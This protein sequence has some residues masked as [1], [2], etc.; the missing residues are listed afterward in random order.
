MPSGCA[1]RESPLS[2]LSPEGGRAGH[3]TRIPSL[4]GTKTH[5]SR[6]SP[7]TS[8]PA[9]F[10]RGPKV[11]L[12]STQR[13]MTWSVLRNVQNQR[14]GERTLAGRSQQPPFLCARPPPLG[15]SFLPVLAARGFLAAHRGGRP[16]PRR[17]APPARPRA[18][19]TC[20]PGP[21]SQ[22]PPRR[23]D[24]LSPCA[25][26]GARPVTPWGAL[27]PDGGARQD[28]G[29]GWPGLGGSRAGP[30]ASRGCRG[31]RGARPGRRRGLTFWRIWPDVD[32]LRMSFC[33]E[34]GSASGS[35][36]D[37]SSGGGGGGG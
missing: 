16:W 14:L 9:G 3:R 8:G 37:D 2:R 35:L 7:H 1:A 33:G 21:G 25:G 4:R 36:S 15:L 5:E 26:R 24:A 10:P 27:R 32:T 19:P 6:K 34:P 12:Q 20:A 17:P 13:E 22:P 29:P 31:V 28:P 23:E 11:S 30:R 18:E